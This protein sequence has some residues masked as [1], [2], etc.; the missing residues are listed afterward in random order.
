MMKIFIFLVALIDFSQCVQPYFP[1]QITFT[2]DAG[3]SIIAIDEINQQAYQILRYG[4]NST[5][6]SFLL[7]H[8]PYALPDSPQSQ[9]Y[10]QLLIDSPPLGCMYGTYW[11]NGGNVFNSFPSHWSNGSFIQVKNYLKFTYEMIHS[12][13]P[14]LTED[15]WY[16]N[17]TC[18]TDDGKIYPCEEI[19]FQKNTEIPLRSTRVIRRGWILV[20]YV[21]NY[22][23]ISMGKLDQ[24]FFDSI[25]K[26]WSMACRDVL[27]GLYITPQTPKIPLHQSSEVQIWLPT[28]PHRINGNDTVTIQWK[29]VGCNDCFMWKP[30]ELSYNGKTFQ[31]KQILTIER[32]KNGSETQLIPIFQ[33]GGFDVV[34][35][36]IYPIY[37]Q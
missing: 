10:V 35:P 19:Y 7:Q 11:K 21:I 31:E 2:P 30:H 16:S 33:G 18:R 28:T 17:V 20:Q 8:F 25:P 3:Q 12:T 23:I 4:Q 13:D 6:N 9:Y 15:Y 27:L 37:L 14:S 29:T 22:R 26:N 36:E 32:V 34:P 5:E 24:K 1:S